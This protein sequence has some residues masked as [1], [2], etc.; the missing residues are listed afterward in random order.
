VA[1]LRQFLD[2]SPVDLEAYG[3]RGRQLIADK[4]STEVVSDAFVAMYNRV[5]GRVNDNEK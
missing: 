4:Y 2:L 3:R 5:V 1:A